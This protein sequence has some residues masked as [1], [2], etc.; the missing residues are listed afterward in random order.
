MSLMTIETRRRWS[1][2]RRSASGMGS[3]GIGELV[4]EGEEEDESF[5]S[6]DDDGADDID[7]G[8]LRR[9][10]HRARALV[11]SVLNKF[12]NGSARAVDPSVARALQQHESRLLSLQCFVEQAGASNAPSP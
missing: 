6:S 7:G 1:S 8:E 12:H 10:Y 11:D 5:W 3:D 9:R 2:G 4:R